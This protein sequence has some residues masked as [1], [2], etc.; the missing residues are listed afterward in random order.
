MRIRLYAPLRSNAVK[1][2]AW[3]S[4]SRNSLIFSSGY[5][6]FI[7]ISFSLQKSIHNRSFLFF[8]GTNMTRNPAGD[9]LGLMNP[10]LMF[11]L[12]YVFSF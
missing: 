11:I 2:F 4:R 1:I 5:Q 12:I 9:S 8:L 7:V 6:F 10:F 3:D